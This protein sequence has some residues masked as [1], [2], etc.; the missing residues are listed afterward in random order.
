M[1]MRKVGEIVVFFSCKNSLYF[2]KIIIKLRCQLRSQITIIY[3]STTSLFPFYLHSLQLFYNFLFLFQ[4]KL[5]GFQLEGLLHIGIR[6]TNLYSILRLGNNSS[7]FTYFYSSIFNYSI[8]I[9]LVFIMQQ[10]LINYVFNDNHSNS[11][12]CL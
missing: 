8:I 5:V 1:T 11:K 9:L 7:S 12:I 3:V 4:S 6:D 10:M 2:F